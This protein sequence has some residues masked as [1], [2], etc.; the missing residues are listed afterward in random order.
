MPSRRGEFTTGRHCAHRALAALGQPAESILPDARGCPEWP[1][2]VVG[3]ITHCDGYRGAA[4]AR[5]ARVRS[6]GIDATPGEPLPDGVL[7]AVALPEERRRVGDLLARWPAVRWDRAL[8]SAKESVYKT[9]YPLLR[10]PLGFEEADVVFQRPQAPDSGTFTARILPPV[11]ERGFPQELTGR[12]LARDGLVL[13][14]IT[15]RP[16]G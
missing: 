13:T 9:W 6:V 4:V 5:T 14:A 16:A 8:F 10:A 2:G 3:S 15:L 12:W 7:E 11:R 1:G